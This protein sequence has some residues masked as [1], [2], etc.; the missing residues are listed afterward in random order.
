MQRFARQVCQQTKKSMRQNLLLLLLIALSFAGCKKDNAGDDVCQDIQR[1]MLAEDVAAMKTII[2]SHIQLLS[3][4]GHTQENLQRLA[5]MLDRK[6]CLSAEIICYACIHTLPEQS[7]IKL[8][9]R[10]GLSTV[11]RIIDIAATSQQ[12]ATMKM[13]NMHK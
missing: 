10:D 5:D 6:S 7:E 2:T 11:T 9:F 12:D 1:A 4:Q 3:S 13:V 8:S